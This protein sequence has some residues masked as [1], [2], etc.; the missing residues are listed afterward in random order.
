M[1]NIF[2]G[3]TA[4]GSWVSP[5]L[6]SPVV[7]VVAMLYMSLFNTNTARLGLLRRVQPIDPGSAVRMFG[8]VQ[9]SL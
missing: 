5:Q 3:L 6:C 8:A 1:G 2:K 7:V 9:G 4:S